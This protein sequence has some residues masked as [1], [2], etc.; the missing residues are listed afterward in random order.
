M[1][2]TKFFFQLGLC[3]VLLTACATSDDE[4][5]NSQQNQKRGMVKAQFTIAF[6]Q[7]TTR[8]AT[9][10]SPDI[11]QVPDAS[12]EDKIP[13]RG[14]KGIE[15]Y[16][17]SAVADDVKSTTAIPESKIQLYG[18]NTTAVSKN[19]VS[20]A[21]DNEIAATGALYKTSSSH[22]YQN[23]DIPLETQSFIF[24]GEAKGS[25]EAYVQ[26]K[27]NKNTAG[28]T[29]LAGITFSLD[30]IFTAS[31]VGSNGTA[32]AAYMTSIANTQVTTGTTSKAWKDT[33]N[34]G[35]RSLYE[36]FTA[37]KTGAW[38]NVKAAVQETY[39][40]L[41]PRPGDNDET[42]AMKA[43]IR[44]KI[45]STPVENV[46][47]TTDTD[48]KKIYTLSFSESYGNYPADLKLPDGAAYIQW[49][50]TELA[51]KPMTSDQN[52]GFN[53]TPLSNFVY[54]AS[55]YYFVKSNIKTSQEHKTAYE[56]TDTWADI[57][58]TYTYGTKVDSKTRSIVITDPVQYGVGR[59]DVT[60]TCATSI[61]DNKNNVI[62]LTKTEGT[63]TEATTTSLFP[64]TGI[65]IGFSGM[66]NSGM[67]AGRRILM[68]DST[69]YMEWDSEKRYGVPLRSD[70]MITA[71]QSLMGKFNSLLRVN[72]KNLSLKAIGYQSG[73]V[74]AEGKAVR[75]TQ[76][77]D[78]LKGIYFVVTL[79]GV[80]GNF[81]PGI[82]YTFDTFTGK[83][84]DAIL[85][86]LNEMRAARAAE[87]PDREDE[88]EKL[89]QEKKMYDEH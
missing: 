33:P 29:T 75:V 50:D 18:T 49:D 38:A 74:D 35:L 23:V 7:T 76:S 52:I 61:L 85:A 44:A 30:P 34:V 55:L 72:I 16:P 79:C 62:A 64:I 88:L 8:G 84:R 27:L 73:K 86:E 77:N 14:I 43:A 87:A 15:L 69:D 89:R 28:A 12:N 54:P 21:A 2:K 36:N 59:L 48:N 40:K 68:A 24:Y 6:P 3:A 60:V 22:L 58:G 10:L 4:E 11:V 31:S 39:N 63:G 42:K 83:R 32:I 1:M 82:I 47:F 81:L 51:F 5:L 17:F 20:G 45:A 78:T 19:G 25:E 57:T 70:G 65:L 41:E 80:I 66:P 26:G 37:I 56:D 46:T 71:V 53:T 13:F 67:G 9:R